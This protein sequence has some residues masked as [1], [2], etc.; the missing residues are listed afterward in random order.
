MFAWREAA[1]ERGLGVRNL[2]P[3]IGVEVSGVDLAAPAD[4]EV[5]AILRAACVERTLLLIRDQAHLSD[6]GYVG[7]A[8][9][10]GDDLDLHSRRDL[11][12]HDHHEIFVVGNVV[13]NGRAAGAAKV[14]LN[15]HTDHY[16]LQHPALFTFLHAITVPAEAGETRYANGIA[17]YESL[18][19]AMQARIE[20]LRVRHSRARLFRELFPDASEE[21]CQAEAERFPDVLHPLVRTHAESGKKGL[22]LGGE[23]GSIIEGDP[24]PEA[25]FAEL[26]AHMTQQGFVHEHHW[27]PGDVLMSDNR[28]SLHRATE[29]DE[30][31]YKR[32]LHRLILLDDQVPA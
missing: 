19:P 4:P 1:A 12:H 30:A 5:T 22:Y 17:A 14:G 9:R 8:R 16:H 7:F 6:A 28:C 29:W 11:C 21:Q 25:L 3:A 32:R 31:Q 26:L 2:G 10:F 23:W 24:E 20:G 15:W 18:S 27:K 13:E